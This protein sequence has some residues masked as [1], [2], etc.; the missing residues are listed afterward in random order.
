MIN[1]ILL[2][3]AINLIFILF[4]H[5]LSKFYNQYDY[6][7]FKRKTQKKP[8]SLL[9][10]SLVV[11]NIF[12]IIFL[13]KFFFS[14]LDYKI[15]KSLF[16]FSLFL[17]LILAFFT[18]GFFDDKLKIQANKKLFFSFIFLSILFF[19]DKTLLIKELTFSFTNEKVFLGNYSFFFTILCFLLFINAFNMLDG[20]NGQAGTYALFLIIILLTKNILPLFIIAFAFCLFAFLILNFSNKTYLGDSGSLTLAFLLSYLFVKS[21]SI[22]AFYADEIFLIMSI[23]GFDLLRLA[24]TRTCKKQ[25]PF[26][27]DNLHIHHLAIKKLGFLKTFILLQILFLFP[28]LLYKAFGNFVYAFFLSLSVYIFLIVIFNKK[29]LR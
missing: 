2:I 26:K 8:I 24:I 12:I 6:P 21:Y 7:D 1:L 10:G 5:P 15:F 28:Y 27:A 13:D 11:V 22:N 18:L 4:F 23:P 19:F 17:L 25:H 3:I 9:G 16:N 14:F 20:I 29:N